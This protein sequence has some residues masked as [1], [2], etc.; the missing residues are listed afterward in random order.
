M[1]PATPQDAPPPDSI[2]AAT[3]TTFS[4]PG[5]MSPSVVGAMRSRWIRTSACI[6]DVSRRSCPSTSTSVPTVTLTMKM[7]SRNTP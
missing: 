7:M 3:P 5:Q 4:S 2:D 6:P 1:N